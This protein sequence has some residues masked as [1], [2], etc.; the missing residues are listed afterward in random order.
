MSGLVINI[1]LDKYNKAFLKPFNNRPGYDM[2]YVSAYVENYCFGTR[3][4]K[5]IETEKL[6]DYF[7]I[8][9]SCETPQQ[10]AIRIRGAMQALLLQLL[11]LRFIF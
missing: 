9:R 11:I 5:V 2:K 7:S 1:T 8:I 10:W 6:Y 4:E 3:L